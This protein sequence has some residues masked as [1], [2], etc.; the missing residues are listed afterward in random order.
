MAKVKTDFYCTQTQTTYRAGD[1]Y[2]GDRTDISHVLDIEKQT[3]TLA[4][5]LKKKPSK[6][7]K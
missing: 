4:P 1:E 2:L 7:A 6:K 3:K 5:E